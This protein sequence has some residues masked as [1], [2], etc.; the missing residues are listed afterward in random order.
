MNAQTA[1]GHDDGQQSAAPQHPL[2]KRLN[3]TA[4]SSDFLGRTLAETE[5]PHPYAGQRQCKQQHSPPSEPDP[6][7][8]RFRAKRRLPIQPPPRG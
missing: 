2:F 1:E 3:Y 7:L 5:P 6:H 8:S 4:P